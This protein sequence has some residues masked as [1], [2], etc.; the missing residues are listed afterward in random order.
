MYGQYDRGGLSSISG[1]GSKK[2]NLFVD[3]SHETERNKTNIF[4]GYYDYRIY[5]GERRFPS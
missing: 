4:G 1:A 2:R 3:I 5:G